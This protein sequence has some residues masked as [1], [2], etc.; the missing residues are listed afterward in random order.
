[1]CKQDARMLHYFVSSKNN[2]SY[3]FQI[4]THV[5]PVCML[6]LSINSYLDDTTNIYDIK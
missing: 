6:R 1:M 2:D 5:D 3:D 4:V